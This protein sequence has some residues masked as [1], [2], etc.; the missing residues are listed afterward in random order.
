DAFIRQFPQVIKEVPEAKLLIV[1]DG[2]QRVKLERIITE[3]G[4]ERQVIITGFQPYQTMPEYINLA[5]ICINTFLISDFSM[6]IMALLIKIIAPANFMELIPIF[7]T[8]AFALFRL[9]PIIGAM[10]SLTMQV[11]GALP[12]CEVVYSIR[13]DEITRIKDGEKELSSLNS[14]IKFNDVSFAYKGRLKILENISTAFEKG[15][16]TAIVGRSGAGKTTIINLLLRLFE[17][18]KGEVRIDGLNI[19][20]Y[21]LSSWLNKIGFVGQDTFI[22]NDT[23]K[24][25]ITFR[26]EKYSDEKVTKAA[27]YADAHS[28]IYELPKGYDTLVGDKGVRLSG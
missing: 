4:L 17:P 10:G 24:N 22:F 6:G 7:G 28:F 12:D 27:K 23:V 1:G 2:P 20:E 19:K 14:S 5:A 8:F 13:T 9:F 25:N 16:T 3:L 21:K 18:D 11:M 26:S 15:K